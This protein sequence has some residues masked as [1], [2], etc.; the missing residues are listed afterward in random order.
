VSTTN[1]SS[2]VSHA[3]PVQGNVPSAIAKYKRYLFVSGDGI[4]VYQSSDGGANWQSSSTGLVALKNYVNTLVVRDSTIFAGTEESGVFRSTDGAASWTSAN[5]GLSSP[6]ISALL[7]QDNAIFAA[8]WPAIVGGTG[9]RP[10]GIFRSTDD[11][12]NWTSVSNGLTDSVVYSLTAKGSSIFATTMSGIFSSTNSG[13]SWNNICPTIASTSMA[14]I[15]NDFFAAVGS[16]IMKS[17]DNGVTWAS[18]SSELQLPDSS[19]QHIVFET[20]NQFLF[21]GVGN[22]VWRYA[23]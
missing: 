3:L 12:I 6:L 7:V 10:G 13:G 14:C 21:A 18:V 4:G 2:W 19:V 5:N 22:W 16:G 17:T 20:N 8:A 9:F 11:G 23:Q 15:G 1:G